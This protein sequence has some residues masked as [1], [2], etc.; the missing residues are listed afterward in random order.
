[1]TVSQAVQA[2]W[3]C[4]HVENKLL[5]NIYVCFI[6]WYDSKHPLPY[7]LKHWDLLFPL[8]PAEGAVPV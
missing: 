8:P 1:M 2:A 6:L 4:L 7:A 5:K 3:N